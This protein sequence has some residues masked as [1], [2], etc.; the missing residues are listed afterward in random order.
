MIGKFRFSLIAM[1]MIALFGF[2]LQNQAKGEPGDDLQF[3]PGVP[4]SNGWLDTK[5]SPVTNSEPDF[6]AA[7]IGTV[8]ASGGANVAGLDWMHQSFLSD[9]VI[10][11]GVGLVSTQQ[12]DVFGFEQAISQAFRPTNMVGAQLATWWSQKDGRNTYVQVTNYDGGPLYDEINDVYYVNVHV[13]ILGDNCE[14]IRNFCDTYTEGDTHVYN[15]GDLVTND[16]QTPDDTVLQGRE[17]FLVVTAVDDC[18]TP[19]QAIDYNYLAGNMTMIDANDYEY[20]V[21]M[22]ARAGLCF[23]DIVNIIDNGSFQD[24]EVE[25]LIPSWVRRQSPTVEVSTSLDFSPVVP[26]PPCNDVLNPECSDSDADLYQAFVASDNDTG[27]GLYYGQNGGSAIFTQ[28]VDPTLINTGTQETNVSVLESSQF[29]VDPTIFDGVTAC[30][31]MGVTYNAQIFNPSDLD[32]F[33][34]CDNYTAICAVNVSG[35]PFFED[36]DL[37]NAD[38]D[39]F[40]WSNGGQSSGSQFLAQAIGDDNLTYNFAPTNLEMQGGKSG[41]INGQL[42]VTPGD[43]YVIQVITGQIANGCQENIFIGDLGLVRGTNGALVD[44]FQL[45][46]FGDECDGPIGEGFHIL[47]GSFGFLLPVQPPAVAG[48]FNVL[49]GNEG[50]AGADVVHINFADQYQPIYR[51]LAAL[52]DAQVGIWDTDEAFTSCGDARVCFVRLGIDADIVISDEF[53]PASPSVSPTATPTMGPVSPTPTP[54]ATSR[55]RGSSSSCAITGPV[56]LGTAMANVLIPLIPLAFVFG[57]RAVRR[58]KK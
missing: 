28:L 36:C 19:D 13:R 29:T 2:V 16:G 55:P 6:S 32:V 9:I 49:P 14:E 12:F 20:G 26:V 38:G 4:I 15:L 25:G 47:D 34:G 40:I 37:Y 23:P 10:D 30:D 39:G 41:V 18:P 56:H 48:Q 21:N 22:Y 3:C 46:C 5:I 52:I 8:E 50:N 42:S 35:T 33:F 51:P 11:D 17:G 53:T 45:L 1:L 57:I 54:T 24:G 7:L 58:R 44:N 27:S 31:T 43:S